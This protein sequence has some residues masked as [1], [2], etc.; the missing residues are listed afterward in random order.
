MI[1]PGEVAVG[2]L[3]RG[4]RRALADFVALTKPRVIVM[5]L[6][7]T[8]VGYY[9]GL[10]GAP[11][12]SHLV[13][14]LIG[15]LLA[16]AGSMA[17][18]QY[19]ERDTDSWMVRTRTR[20]LPDGRLQPPDALVFGTL[21]AFA[22]VAY[23]L[24]LVGARP[25]AVTAS[26]VVLYVL[27]YTPLKR[28]SPVCTLVGAVPGA[29]PPVIGWVAARD[30]LGTG[31]WVL[32]GILFFWQLPH[33]LAIGRLYRDDYARAGLRV[34]AVLD[35]KGGR[36]ERQITRSSLALL[37]V[38]LI[39]A[40][41]GMAGQLYLAGAV[42]L[43]GMMLALGARAMR[44]PSLAAARRVLY[45]SLLYLPALLGLLALDKL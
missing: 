38:S 30:E 5:I 27:A 28:R 29:L 12:W 15:T 9:V 31:A 17:L 10:V 37:V 8:V 22:G 2:T 35:V 34:L 14:V 33:T 19:W 36:T 11:E 41:V 43:G 16:A 6:V 21:L 23:L 4:R 26:T 3:I 44:V 42:A 1:P 39:P 7:T 13:H 24:V 40:V 45:G 25:A 18:N 32:F 20:P